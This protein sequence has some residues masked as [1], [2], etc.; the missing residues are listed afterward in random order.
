MSDEVLWLLNDKN[1]DHQASKN[2]DYQASKNHDHQA[3]QIFF[4]LEPN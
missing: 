4:E 3:S 2:D 1:D